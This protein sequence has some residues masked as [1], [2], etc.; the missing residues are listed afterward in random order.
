MGWENFPPPQLC[1]IAAGGPR[2]EKEKKR[3]R[4]GKR[5]RQKEKKGKGR[6]K[7]KKIVNYRYF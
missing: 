5:E 2:G 7:K 4:K 3:G 1:K 6:E